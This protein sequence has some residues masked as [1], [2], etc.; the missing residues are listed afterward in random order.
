MNVITKIK[1]HFLMKKYQK[2]LVKR[3][4]DEL[5]RTFSNLTGL[6]G[7]IKVNKKDIRGNYKVT[8]NAKKIAK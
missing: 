1:L 7:F 5:K 6:E 3:M 4:G 2:E 8:I